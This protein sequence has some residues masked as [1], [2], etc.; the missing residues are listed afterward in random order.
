MDQDPE[1]TRLAHALR[2]GEDFADTFRLI[3]ERLHAQVYRYFI[4]KG[5]SD[6]ESRELAQDVF[7]SVYRKVHELRD[8]HVFLGWLFTIARNRYFAYL[9]HRHAQKRGSATTVEK[10]REGSL[11][12]VV[13]RRPGVLDH[14]LDSEKLSRMREAMQDLPEQMRRCVLMRV[15]EEAPLEQIASNCGISVNTVKAHL[16][17]ARKALARRLKPYFG[18]LEF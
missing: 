8:E 16:H 1:L 14:M 15:L 6:E 10:N 2:T 3:Y 4:R 13:D 18:E 9:E 11:E 5:I 12:Y 7:M 17:Q